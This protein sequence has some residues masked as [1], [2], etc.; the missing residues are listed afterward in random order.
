MSVGP[1]A[2]PAFDRILGQIPNQ[3]RQRQVTQP[4]GQQL[5]PPNA[6]KLWG[7]A[8]GHAG[9]PSAPTAERW[10]LLA[11]LAASPSSRTALGPRRSS[12]RH[13][14]LSMQTSALPATA[15]TARAPADRSMRTCRGSRAAW[16]RQ[17][18]RQD[19][20]Q[21]RPSPLPPA[22]SIGRVP[23]DLHITGLEMSGIQRS[24]NCLL[25][26]LDGGLAHAQRRAGR[27]RMPVGAL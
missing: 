1:V 10:F 6:T 7:A 13:A 20:S 4:A 27:P 16:M 19:R 25:L 21:P 15:S 2:K 26:A 8:A 5:H 18:S 12:R 14:P 3:L 23:A 22:R 9:L 24:A 17:T 11:V